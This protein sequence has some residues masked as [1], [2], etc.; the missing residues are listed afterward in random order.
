MAEASTSVI[1]VIL[2]V[3]V[4]LVVLITLWVF[5]PEL[6]VRGCNVLPIV[7]QQLLGCS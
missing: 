6:L 7:V 2:I 4:I 3:F 1:D 5:E